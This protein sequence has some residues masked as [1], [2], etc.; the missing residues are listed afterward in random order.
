[1]FC[2]LGVG[3]T[4]SGVSVELLVLTALS[5]GGLWSRSISV[6]VGEL[7][8]CFVGRSLWLTTFSLGLVGLW[9]SA[10]FL[11]GLEWCNDFNWSN[12]ITFVTRN[13]IT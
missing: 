4:G 12:E 13:V 8:T 7:D 1:M 11:G 9:R 10:R 3:S 6:L 5:L 2:L